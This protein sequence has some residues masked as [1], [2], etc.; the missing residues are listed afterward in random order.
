[1]KKDI[2]FI[3]PLDNNNIPKHGDSIKNRHLVNFFKQYRTVSCIDTWGWKKRPWLLLFLIYGVF[4]GNYKSI[5]YSVSNETAY[6]LTKLFTLFPIPKK[7]IYFMI[8]GYTPIKIAQGIY[9][10]EPFRKLDKIIVEADRCKEFYEEVDIHNALTVYNF[11]PYNFSPNLN[12]P[13][14]G[15]IKFVFL[16]RLTE[17]KGIFLILNAI[18]TLNDNGYSDRFEVDYYG[19]ISPE[20]K[21]RF[22]NEINN[23]KNAFYK[24]FLNLMD[25]NNYNVLS[26]Y[27]ALLFPTM[28]PTEG[29]PG[30]IADAAIAGVPVIASNWNYAEELVA[31]PGCGYIVP[32]GDVD[33]LVEKMMYIIDNRSENEKLRSVCVQRATIYKMSNV[34]TT[35]LLNN[36]GI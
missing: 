19:S 27:D 21:E 26:K 34:L 9:K 1:M 13:H 3:G 10:A 16:S 12:L 30:V 11:K 20:V 17:L 4:F 22:L 18:K 29:F 23:F 15:K 28:H 7:L 24:G 31:A 25:E 6:K 32:T 8:G 35:N 33:A 2:L 36:I 14:S 5:V